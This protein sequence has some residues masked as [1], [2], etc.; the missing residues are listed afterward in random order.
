[1]AGTTESNS[2]ADAVV[3]LVDVATFADS[4]GDGIGDLR[5]LLQRLD[6]VADLGVV[7]LCPLPV[8]ASPWREGGFDIAD[9]RAV[10]PALGRLS[11][12]RVLVRE[13]HRR[14]LR[15]LLDLVVDSTS[16]E[17]AWFQRARR[18]KP[19]TA[20]RQRYVWSERAD[21]YRDAPVLHPESERSNWTWD[22]LAGAFY[23][24]RASPQQPSLNLD[25]AAVRRELLS[26]MRYW[27]R[28]G[29]DGLRLHG[30]STLLLREGTRCIDLPENAAVVREWR[31]AIDAAFED[32]TLLAR[33]DADVDA[34]AGYFADGAGCSAVQEASWP[35]RVAMALQLEA[36][37]PLVD[38]LAGQPPAPG[39]ARRLL[40]IDDQDGAGTAT[41]APDE[42]AFLQQCY[43]HKPSAFR[44]RALLRRLAPLMDFDESRIRLALTLL[45]SLPGIPM[46]YYGD[47][48]AMGDN[49]HLRD[50]AGMRTPMQW[51]VDRNAGFSSAES[52]RLHQPVH[53]DSLGGYTMANVEFQARSPASLL[54]W[55]RRTIQVRRRHPAFARGDLVLLAPANPAVLAFLRRSADEALLCVA[56]LSR[57]PQAVQLDLSSFAGSVPIDLAT[58]TNFPPIGQLP[59]LLTLAPLACQWMSLA[60]EVERIS[61]F[62]SHASGDETL[63]L[64]LA[65]D[66]RRHRVMCWKA[67]GDLPIGDDFAQR[68]VLA[69]RRS[70]CLVVLLSREA[71]GSRWVRLEVETALALERAPGGRTTRVLPVRLDDAVHQ[72][73]EDWVAA[74]RARHIGDFR[75]W[76]DPDAY[77]ASLH[78][79]LSAIRTLA[80][81][82]E[83]R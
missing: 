23:R 76:T 35:A 12:L 21:R 78:E 62:I 16:V 77:A 43:P 2:L 46:L 82:G 68:L 71:L 25:R 53:G 19:G 81:A 3:Y 49:I 32:R 69:V 6:H 22:D 47:E 64:Q 10:H 20:A 75:T 51:N 29:V 70:D 28:L 56:N 79:L 27:L 26:A 38:L 17:H 83:P 39:T 50:G 1:M 4:N 34:A 33:V 40:C 7:A 63:A 65:Q 41:L 58:R 9:H 48:I 67:P 13:T 5:G 72:A 42:L 45:L 73:D 15:L 8:F 14:G 30:V 60:G 55:L 74:C 36:R 57:H 11:D 66:L 31:V 52:A 44:R 24:H 61:C 59:M 54:N 18:A 80:R 37:A